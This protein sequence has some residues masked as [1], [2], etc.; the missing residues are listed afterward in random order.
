L[1][2]GS[3]GE[4][5]TFRNLHVQKMFPGT[6]LQMGE[7]IIKL[8]EPR[9]PC[10]VLYAVSESLKE[11]IIGRCGYM[12]SVLQEGTIMPGASIVVQQH[13]TKTD[14]ELDLTGNSP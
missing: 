1:V 6:I 12:A 13:V 8:E 11:N 3:I 2:P 4:N 14:V 5:I 10:Y 7:V 9:K